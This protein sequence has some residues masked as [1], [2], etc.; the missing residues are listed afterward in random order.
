M[1]SCASHAIAAVG[2]V[3]ELRMSCERRSRFRSDALS[4]YSIWAS[5]ASPVSSSLLG[6]LL[7]FM[8]LQWQPR[9][10]YLALTIRSVRLGLN[11]QTFRLAI[12]LNLFLRRLCCTMRNRRRA[13]RS[14]HSPPDS[15]L[16]VFS[17][18]ITRQKH[19]THLSRVISLPSHDVCLE[20]SQ[21]L[22]EF[23]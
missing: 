10:G 21:T 4:F 2:S 18:R 3:D 9:V 11:V 5:T 23:G 15:N 7:S 14:S 19:L 1:E 13:L 6:Y 8:V 16:A 17:N 20:Y 12:H 22:Y